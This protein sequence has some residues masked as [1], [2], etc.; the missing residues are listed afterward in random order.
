MGDSGQLSDKNR[1]KRDTWTTWAHLQAWRKNKPRTEGLKALEEKVMPAIVFASF[2]V[3][4][5]IL[6]SN[7]TGR[8]IGSLNQTSSN[9][10]GILF[11]VIALICVLVGTKRKK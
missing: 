5:I 6:S 4:A 1:Q 8:V 10:I 7:I 3:S 9:R 2:V 11:I